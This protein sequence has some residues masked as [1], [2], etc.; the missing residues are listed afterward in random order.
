MYLNKVFFRNLL[1]CSVL[2]A[3]F[4]ACS[5]DDDVTPVYS[6]TFTDKVPDGCT[7]ESHTIN[8]TEINTGAVTTVTSTDN[9]QLT[10]GT[11]NVDATA[12]AS[13][14]DNG[15][16]TEK[17]LRAV[18][19][20]VVINENTHSISLDWYFFNPDNSLVFSEIYVSGS[21]NATGKGALYDSFFRFYN[22]TDEV[23]YA[24][25]LALCESKFTNA[26]SITVLTEANK[27]EN[28]FT[29]QTI[30]VIPGNGTDVPIQPGQ[31]IKIVDQA[32]D[33]TEQVSN[34]LDHRDATFEW[35][36]EVTT[37]S[38]RDTDNPD[39]PNLDKWFSYSA[40]IWLP[41]QQC[42]KSYALVR[43]PEGM[44]AEK[45]LAEYNGDYTYLSSTGK[46][47]NGNK[48]YI[49]PNSWI[50]DG[51]N[52]CVAQDFK[53]ASLAP[54]ID[55]SYASIAVENT[56]ANRTGKKFR[57]RQAGNSPA[58]N[59]ILMDTDDSANDFEVVSAK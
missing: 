42:N 48:A 12:K 1:V 36:D 53:M 21:L 51:V 45:F 28:N 16:L 20:N 22:N 27:P 47:M 14:T 11:Y 17:S 4:S 24:D 13:Y 18:A 43:M 54:S 55:K 37:G 10:A 44:T 34:A 15:T 32:I 23:I 58:G 39:V 41:N 31:S 8:F 33:W 46:E 7:I 19:Q 56:V 57:R 38:V 5:E 3:G 6:V 30:Y 35:Y 40:T 29:A 50:L 59:V 2:A 26:T 25:G 52:L 9:L 49:I